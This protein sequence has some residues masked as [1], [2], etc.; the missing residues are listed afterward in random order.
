[1]ATLVPGHAAVCS[2]TRCRCTLRGP[3]WP[4]RL[5]RAPTGK[6]AARKVL[7]RGAFPPTMLLSEDFPRDRKPVPELRPGIRRRQPVG[8]L[9]NREGR[10]VRRRRPY[11]SPTIRTATNRFRFL[12]SGK[13]A[14]A[15]EPDGAALKMVEK[16]NLNHRELRKD[17]RDILEQIDGE[18]LE[19]SDFVDS[20]GK[21][22][23]SYAHVVC[24]RFGGVIP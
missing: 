22:A 7:S 14:S 8:N 24:Q 23:Q 6:V 15:V 11:P 9:W 21:P 2:P 10:L 4:V 18:T 12:L 5:L 19:L 17:R 16:L 13:I 1:M 3:A 20:T